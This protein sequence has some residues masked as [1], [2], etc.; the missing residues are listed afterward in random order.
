MSRSVLFFIGLA[1]A[2]TLAG[3]CSATGRS[4]TFDD[5]EGEGGEDPGT[6]GKGAGMDPSG[7]G[8]F[9][10][11]TSGAGGGNM[12]NCDN[13]PDADGDMD[14]WTQNEGDCNNCDPNVNPG[15]VEVIASAADMDGGPPPMSDEDCDMQVDEDEICDTGL[16]LNDVNP[17]SGAKAI[18]ICNEVMPGDKKWGVLEAKYV[19]A[20][21]GFT[22]PSLQAG[23]LDNFGPNVN[24]QRGAKLLSL[25][26]GHAR[27][28][29]DPDE[30]GYSSCSISGGGAP[31]PGFPQD[32]PGCSGLSNINDD[33]ALEL[34]MRAPTNA[35]GY[36]FLFKFYSIE[37][38][39]YVCTAFNDQ[40]IALV[41]PPP[42]GSINGNISF[43]SA[44]NPVSVN[45]AFFDVCDPNGIGNFASVCGGCKPVPNPYCPSG[46]AELQGNGFDGAWGDAGGT[47]WLQTAAPIAPGEE[48]S[49]RF[50][51][52][53][54]GDTALDSTVV[55]DG[56][57]WIATGGTV[58]VGTGQVPDPK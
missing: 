30:C 11:T 16:A 42:M 19:R 57:E 47:S 23:I 28:P 7:V 36:K 45:V 56:F 24:V 2:I 34:K 14:G 31:P 8:G 13:A 52:W 29:G 3:A 50:A 5:E 6:S 55:I 32:V 35:T 49:I 18:D 21:G 4:N 43:D 54:T 33:V 37:F 44:K 41:T 17:M 39:E 48:F 12:V 15:A 58:T 1:G 20:S 40:F 46:T 9:I 25:S 38:P 51:I 27:L 10:P 53:D 22:N 26:S